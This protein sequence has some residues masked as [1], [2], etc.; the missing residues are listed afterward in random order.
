MHDIKKPRGYKRPTP[1]RKPAMF[2]TLKDGRRVP[3][4]A[5]MCAYLKVEMAKA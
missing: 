2:I 3:T 1:R 5:A 4:F